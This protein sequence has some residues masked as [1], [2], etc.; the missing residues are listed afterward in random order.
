[1]YH[2]WTSKTFTFKLILIDINDLLAITKDKSTN[3]F[4]FQLIKPL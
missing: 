1:M 3:D 2:I 4:K